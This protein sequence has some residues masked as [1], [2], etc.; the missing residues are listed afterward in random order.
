MLAL[1]RKSIQIS[2]VS[3]LALTGNQTYA[4][5][6]NA[7]D[8]GIFVSA[9]VGASQS[10]SYIRGATTYFPFFAGSSYDYNFDSQNSAAGNIAI[11][12]KVSFGK[13]ATWNAFYT[14]GSFNYYNFGR[15]VDPINSEVS[16]NNTTGEV[17][18]VNTEYTVLNAL[19]GE[20]FIGKYL[21]S[22]FSIEAG[23]GIG[24]NLGS[25]NQGVMGIFRFK[26]GYDILDNLTVFA[27]Y[28]GAGF[29][30]SNWNPVF[31]FSY[32]DFN[33]SGISV[34]SEQIGLEYTF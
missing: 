3:L 25:T 9:S 17:T 6:Y 8:S 20:L 16:K 5:Y 28:V 22:P 32:L 15:V 21:G 12:Y 30:K 34:N 26:L 14:G 4:E 11:G 27:Q 18:V 13:K 31:F 7:K 19:G 2:L 1:K 23:L 24:G 29:E 10:T 33:S